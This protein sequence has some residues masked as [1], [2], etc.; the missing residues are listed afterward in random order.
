VSSPSAPNPEDVF[1]D[2]RAEVADLPG[3]ADGRMFQSDG[4]TF[5]GKFFAALSRGQLLVKLPADRVAA[6]IDDGIGL[7]F[8]ANRGRPMREWMLVPVAEHAHWPS[9]AKEALTFAQT[10][11]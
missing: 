3:V 10:K 1:E 8:D 2:L 6:L 9:I 11:R 5:G 4:L 7:P